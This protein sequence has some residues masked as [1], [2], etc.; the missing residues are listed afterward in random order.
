MFVE[1]LK[2]TYLVDHSG[3]TL[4]KREYENYHLNSYY[5]TRQDI[6]EAYEI[7]SI[8]IIDNMK[9]QHQQQIIDYERNM[10]KLSNRISET[11]QEI[12]V[13]HKRISE[14]ED[15]VTVENSVEEMEAAINEARGFYS[16]FD[17]NSI[18]TLDFA[19]EIDRKVINKLSFIKLPE[20][21]GL[22]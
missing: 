11:T 8:Q 18:L 1:W 12:E 22:S 16:K 3:S 5:R 6:S 7:K 19:N 9:T 15:K 13:S 21:K 20:I 10:K 17:P 14:L 4:Y 2:Y